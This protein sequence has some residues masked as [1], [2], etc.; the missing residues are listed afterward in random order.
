[1]V[2]RRLFLA[3]LCLD[4]PPRVLPFFVAIFKGAIFFGTYPPNDWYD[5]E[6]P[7]ILLGKPMGCALCNNEE[8]DPTGTGLINDELPVP[9]AIII[10][11][12]HIKRFGT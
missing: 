8:F 9:D 5:A 12:V 10:Y 7:P 1:M 2:L 4:P 11:F 6:F 3:R